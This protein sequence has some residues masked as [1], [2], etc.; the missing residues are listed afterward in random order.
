MERR[1]AK[2]Q[3]ESASFLQADIRGSRQ[4]PIGRA[5]GDLGQAVHRTWRD[6]HPHAGKASRCD[7][8]SDIGIRIGVVRHAAEILDA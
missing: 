2:Q 5:M 7:R 1:L 3:H 6:D 8:C 4:K